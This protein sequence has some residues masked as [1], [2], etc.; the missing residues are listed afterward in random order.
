MHGDDL[1]LELG[2]RA[3]KVST[4]ADAEPLKV[5][6]EEPVLTWQQGSVYFFL[7]PVLVCE[8]PK[9]TVGLGDAISAAA[10]GAY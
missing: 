2:I 4:A 10:I 9:V 7:A 3:V 5:T 1:R 8:K 6:V